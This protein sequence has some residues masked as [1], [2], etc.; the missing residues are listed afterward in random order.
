MHPRFPLPASEKNPEFGEVPDGEHIVE[1]GK[2]STIHE[3]DELTLVTFEVMVRPA[4]LPVWKLAR[5]RQ[6]SC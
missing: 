2:A 3:D 5:E 4:M 1:L 6:H